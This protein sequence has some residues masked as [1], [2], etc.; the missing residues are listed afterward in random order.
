MW[1]RTK[2]VP[3]WYIHEIRGVCYVSWVSSIDKGQ[4]AVFPEEYAIKWAEILSE[5]TGF[6]LEIIKPFA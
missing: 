4:A 2:T 3:A 1:I 5:T 6:D